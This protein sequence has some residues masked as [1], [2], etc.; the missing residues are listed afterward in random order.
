MKALVIRILCARYSKMLIINMGKN[1]EKLAAYSDALRHYSTCLQLTN[2]YSTDSNKKKE[3]MDTIDTIKSKLVA[4]SV[5]SRKALSLSI[6]SACS[7]ESQKMLLKTYFHKLPSIATSRN[8]QVQNINTQ[9]SSYRS[10]SKNLGNK[11]IRNP[12]NTSSH[13]TINTNKELYKKY[14]QNKKKAQNRITA[15]LK[16][17][18]IEI[19]TAKIYW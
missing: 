9:F 3:L 18:K 6:E 13:L 12:F 7:T 11:T 5:H 19:G 8:K 2:A 15:T 10:N 4:F 17:F 1:Y 16:K 14:L